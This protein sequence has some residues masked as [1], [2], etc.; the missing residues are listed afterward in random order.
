[1]RNISKYDKAHQIDVVKQFKLR[2]AHER[3][4]KKEIVL[5]HIM[6]LVASQFVIKLMVIQY[7]K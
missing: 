1:M 3:I 2:Y 7:Y 5:L 6:H 4:S